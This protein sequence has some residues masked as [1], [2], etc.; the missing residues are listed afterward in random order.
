[1]EL[2]VFD[3]GFR[4]FYSFTEELNF[5]YGVQR[6]VW[7]NYP[8]LECIVRD[9]KRHKTGDMELVIWYQNRYRPENA[10]EA[11]IQLTLIGNE[12]CEVFRAMDLEVTE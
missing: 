12:I 5:Y 1:M 2:H 9:D 6:Y 11:F 7:E 4:D 3:T 10:D 8:K